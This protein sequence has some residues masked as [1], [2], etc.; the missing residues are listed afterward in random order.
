MNKR[1]ISGLAALVVALTGLAVPS[2]TA[3]TAPSPAPVAGKVSPPRTEEP[4]VTKKYNPDGSITVGSTL[5]TNQVAAAT[6]PQPIEEDEVQVVDGFTCEETPGCKTA[7]ARPS[8]YHPW[9]WVKAGLADYSICVEER[10]S[11]IAQYVEAIDHA[12]AQYNARSD[13]FAWDRP[14]GGCAAV[15]ENRKTYFRFIN[16]PGNNVCATTYTTYIPPTGTAPWGPTVRSR[17]EVNSANYARCNNTQAR[18]FYVFDH[19]L[20]HTFTLAHNLNQNST[21]N[22]SGSRPTVLDPATDIPRLEAAFHD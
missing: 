22:D 1:F 19:E 14:N 3:S 17:I 8:Y 9:H 6:D 18:R 5:T 15:P 16:T 13:I 2:A 20:G 7:Q 10:M 4:T 11:G 21:M 12:A